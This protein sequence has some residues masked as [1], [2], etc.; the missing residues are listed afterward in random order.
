MNYGPGDPRAS[1]ELWVIDH[2]AERWSSDP[3][4]LDV[5]ANVGDYAVEVLARRPDARL[6]C[7]EPSRVTRELLSERLSGRASI[8]EFGLGSS[9]E[10]V[11]LYSNEP[12][13]G[14]ASVHPRHLDHLGV[15]FEPVERVELRRLDRVFE[16][17]ELPR[18]DLLKLDV[19]GN[20]LAALQGAERMLADRS[21]DAIQFEFGGADI[22]SRVFFRDFYELLTPHYRIHRVLRDGLA[23]VDAYRETAEIFVTSNFLCLV[24]SDP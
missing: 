23:P 8:H 14:M 21:I 22:D 11:T 1:G 4:V 15:T 6:H 7:F 10:V 13:S 16:E 19:E 2:L 17:L 3:I 18:V 24:R 12:T 5:G 20:E 9:D